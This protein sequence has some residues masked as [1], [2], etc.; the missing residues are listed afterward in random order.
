MCEEFCLIC[1]QCDK[2]KNGCQ[3]QRGT[4]FLNLC[5]SLT[6]VCQDQQ[7]TEEIMTNLT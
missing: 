7:N 1:E 3:G 2:F 6:T 4:F 5:S